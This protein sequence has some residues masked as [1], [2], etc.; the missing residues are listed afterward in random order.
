MSGARRVSFVSDRRRIIR[1]IRS[2]LLR[3]TRLEEQI[4][5]VQPTPG[6]WFL[7]GRGVSRHRNH[8]QM[9]TQAYRAACPCKP[10]NE[11]S[12]SIARIDAQGD[13]SRLFQGEPD[14]DGMRLRAPSDWTGKDQ[15][16]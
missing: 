1:S 2:F 11:T 8:V 4:V 16:Q 12:R 13:R 14:R 5:V 9:L 15:W 7:I 6:E 10:F 3:G